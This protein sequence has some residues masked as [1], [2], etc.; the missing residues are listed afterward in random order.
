MDRA[1]DLAHLGKLDPKLWSV[2]S[3]PTSGLEIDRRT[4]ELIDSDHDGHIR[5]AEILDAVSWTCKLLKDPLS[6]Q[7]CC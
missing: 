3:S 5:V 2:L 1:E 6:R 4:L 7:F